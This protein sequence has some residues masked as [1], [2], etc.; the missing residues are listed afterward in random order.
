M[1]AEVPDQ[2]DNLLQDISAVPI[3]STEVP[4]HQKESANAIAP[5]LEGIPGKS[6][7]L[8]GDGGSTWRRRMQRRATE[9]ATERGTLCCYA[10][11]L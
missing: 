9:R 3:Q 5:R 10:L 6:G 4:K 1:S 2:M 8:V 11:W 7:G